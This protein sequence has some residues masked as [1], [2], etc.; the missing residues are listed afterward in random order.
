MVL[1][2]LWLLSLVSCTVINDHS[3]VFVDLSWYELGTLVLEWSIRVGN[4]RG[5]IRT[6][7]DESVTGADEPALV[8]RH[9]HHGD[10]TLVDQVVLQSLEGARTRSNH[11][12]H[13]VTAVL[14][15]LELRAQNAV[16]MDVHDAI[17]T[18]VQT[19]EN[20]SGCD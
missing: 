11:P 6:T 20:S 18:M 4:V 16:I 12:L 19:L 1:L 3:I 17:V 8:L 7:M 5:S 2:M 10:G 15:V 14:R 9:V 13:R